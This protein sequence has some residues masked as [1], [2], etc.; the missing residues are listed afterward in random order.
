M[1]FLNTLMQSGGNSE[2]SCR[3]P[4]FKSSNDE[5][6]VYVVLVCSHSTSNVKVFHQRYSDLKKFHDKV[7]KSVT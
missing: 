3:I 4:H 2:Y 6:V 7:D 1:M 5:K